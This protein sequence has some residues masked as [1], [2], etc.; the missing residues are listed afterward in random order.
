LLI[1]R[2]FLVSEAAGE[3]AS[4]EQARN[5]LNARHESERIGGR[6]PSRSVDTILVSRH[7]WILVILFDNASRAQGSRTIGWA[8]V[9]RATGSPWLPDLAELD[10]F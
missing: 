9:A 1:S 10:Q 7:H 8:A 3:I 2:V 4:P 5:T 6:E